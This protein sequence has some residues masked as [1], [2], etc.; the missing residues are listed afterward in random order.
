MFEFTQDWT[1]LRSAAE[2]ATAARAVTDRID[3]HEALILPL[4]RPIAF[5][6]VLG[7]MTGAHLRERADRSLLYASVGSMGMPML[8]VLPDSCRRPLNAGSTPRLR[9][10]DVLALLANN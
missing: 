1:G 7:L 6:F 9:H 4:V 8:A 2:R 10:A 3:R 5:L